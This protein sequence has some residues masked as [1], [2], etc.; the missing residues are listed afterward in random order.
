MIAHDRC[1]IATTDELFVRIQAIWN[2]LLQAHIQNM[3]D[4]MPC[5]IAARGGFTKY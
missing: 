2:A 1:S 5:R 4:S 3:F